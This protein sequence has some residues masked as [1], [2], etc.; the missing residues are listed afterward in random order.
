MIEL[1]GVYKGYKSGSFFSNRYREVLREIDL[2]VR[3]GEHLGIIG[4]SG[5]GKTTLSKIISLLELPDRGEL[6]VDGEAVNRKNIKQKRGTVGMVFQDP[7]TSLDPSMRIVS[8]LKEA[9]SD[10]DR[11]LNVFEKVGLKRE[12]LDKYPHQLSGGEQQ[13]V[14][15]ARVLLSRSSYVIFD[16]FTSALDVSTQAR[17]VNLLLKI[18]ER[19]QYGF[20]FVS[21]D[22][23][24]IGYLS[25]RIYVIYRGEI[26]EELEKLKQAKHPYTKA[27]LNNESLDTSISDINDKGCSFYSLCPYRLERCKEQKPRLRVL[28]KNNK[29]RCFLYD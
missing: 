13:R 7:S 6:F 29:V 26:V 12:L 9:S 14:A 23:K 16:E 5:A 15:I 3:V 8:T 28:G 17:I 20:V 19:K 22:V 27:L 4:E 10:K 1:K 11:I 24:L 18:N 21:H 2:E 25:D